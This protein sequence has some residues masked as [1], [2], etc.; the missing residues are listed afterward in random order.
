MFLSEGIYFLDH[1]FSCGMFGKWTAR[2]IVPRS[3]QSH[4]IAGT[5]RT[6]HHFQNLSSRVSP[7]AFAA[8]IICFRIS[9][10]TVWTHHLMVLLEE[11]P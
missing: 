7:I 5:P 9:T 10:E 3:C 4:A 8:A 11:K 6:V 2:E 1:F